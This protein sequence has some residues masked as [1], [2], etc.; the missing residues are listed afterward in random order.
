MTKENTKTMLLADDLD[1]LLEV[2][3][4]FIKSSLENHPQKHL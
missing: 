2:L 1:Q 3:P 4:S